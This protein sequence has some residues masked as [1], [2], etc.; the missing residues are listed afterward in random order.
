MWKKPELVIKMWNDLQG[1]TWKPFA[2]TSGTVTLVKGTTILRIAA[3]STAGGTVV[4]LGGPT[5]TIP[6]AADWLYLDFQ[7]TYVTA[8]VSGSNNAG[9]TI[10]FTSTDA[11][12]IDTLVA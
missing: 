3:H 2:G 5:I 12:Y 9:L 10:V 6:A 1:K 8:G 7:H 11:Y 4:V